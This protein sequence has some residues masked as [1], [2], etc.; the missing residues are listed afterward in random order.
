MITREETG[1]DQIVYGAIKSSE[2][3]GS[4]VPPAVRVTLQKRNL[5]FDTSFPSGLEDGPMFDVEK[6]DNYIYLAHLVGAEL[7][8]KLFD[9]SSESWATS[10]YV[11]DNVSQFSFGDPE[12]LFVLSGGIVYRCTTLDNWYSLSQGE[13]YDPSSMPNGTPYRLAATDGETLYVTTRIDGNTRFLKLTLS[14]ASWSDIYWP[15]EITGMD[16]IRISGAIKRDAIVVTTPLPYQFGLKAVG[17]EVETVALNRYGMVAFHVRDDIWS[18]HFIIEQF[19][20]EDTTQQ[21]MYPRITQIDSNLYALMTWGIDG[22][23]SYNHATHHLYL[24][25]DMK[26]FQIDEYIDLENISSSAR[27][28]R[29][30]D[31][32]YAVSRYGVVRSYSTEIVGYTPAA[33]KEDITDRVLSLSSSMQNVRSTTLTLA[34]ADG[35]LS[36]S[37]LSQPGTFS[38]LTELGVKAPSEGYALV[39]HEII[40]RVEPSENVREHRVNIVARDLGGLLIDVLSPNVRENESQLVAA[41]DFWDN[42][43]S[44][45]GG[46]RHTAG[47]DGNWKSDNNALQL[48]SNNKKGVAA[49]TFSSRIWNGSISSKVEWGYADKGE[50][51]GLAFRIYDKDNF[52]ACIYNTEN[53]KIELHSIRSG[54]WTKNTESSPMGWALGGDYWV[55]VV[56]RYSLIQV[57]T[58]TDGKVWSFEFDH[59]LSGE[60]ARGMYSTGE[61]P[62]EV[63]SVGYT[64]YGYTEEL[65]IDDWNWNDEPLD[66]GI[67]IPGS[68]SDGTGEAIL[69]INVSNGTYNEGIVLRTDNLASAVWQDFMSGLPQV[70]TGPRTKEICYINLDFH[71]PNTALVFF[72]DGSMYK[73]SN[74]RGGGPWELL[75]D[76][77]TFQNA[78]ID[79]YVQVYPWQIAEFSLVNVSLS[80]SEKGR[81]YGV[82]HDQY[83]KTGL[84]TVKNYVNLEVAPYLLGR[85]NYYGSAQS[86]SLDS[87]S[88]YGINT[89]TLN[90]GAQYTIRI[91]GLID[92][93]NSLHRYTDA[94]W[95]QKEPGGP[96]VRKDMILFDGTTLQSDD[97]TFDDVNH[98]YD[99]TVIGDGTTMNIKFSDINYFDNVGSFRVY[100]WDGAPD[101]NLLIGSFFNDDVNLAAS[102][103]NGDRVYVAAG[104][105]NG[106]E[107]LSDSYH[108][109][110]IDWGNWNTGIGNDGETYIV[111]DESDVEPQKRDIGIFLPFYAFDG[112]VNS[113]DLEGYVLGPGGKILKTLDN[114]ANR[115][116]WSPDGYRP[117]IAHPDREVSGPDSFETFGQHDNA[118]AAFI[119]AGDQDALYVLTNPSSP[120]LES[121]WA[122]YLLGTSNSVVWM[123]GWP[124]K[125]GQFYLGYSGS[126]SDKIVEMTLDPNSGFSD[127]TGNIR[128]LASWNDG[129]SGTGNF[130]VVRL[131]PYWG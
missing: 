122:Q 99:F 5:D 12:T 93:D 57:Y 33:I 71:D 89:Y 26:S 51:V 105:Y 23:A 62:L 27:L 53:D 79:T 19:D 68:N 75:I 1:L 6:D 46:L 120:E 21:R 41:D 66:T 3:N 118:K 70:P 36:N 24:S 13:F 59:V 106:Q 98:E 123:G 22:N 81:F 44:G 61:A 82:I 7:Y 73:N 15:H 29:H 125:G 124:Y 117:I 31:Y 28:F 48:T 16:A 113:D 45:Y 40:D 17:S 74:W 103:T 78:I 34:N 20:N 109:W 102:H 88:S 116:A 4:L 97:P 115:P 55:K 110:R 9:L 69:A 129:I 18:E 50:F 52:F 91:S 84:I 107:V 39:S 14:G 2:H 49:S 56:F 90:N 108:I 85:V 38:L 92:Y 121:S 43:G 128:S 96:F 11:A 67:I 47:L 76:S 87:S 131:T 37:M 100:V 32:V 64:G 114:F 42:T 25:P 30:G 126:G 80:M 8:V 83:G 101:Y 60:K 111:P 104:L 127:L 54:V 35:W 72:T 119:Q 112:S 10:F 77:S 130:W 86:F 63:G 58:S 94:Q 95:Y 65:G